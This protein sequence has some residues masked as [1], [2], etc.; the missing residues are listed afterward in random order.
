MERKVSRGHADKWYKPGGIEA[1]LAHA[2]RRLA[3]ERRAKAE[4]AFLRRL[5]DA[6]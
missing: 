3:K 5:R 4:Q 2:R 1:R 6:A